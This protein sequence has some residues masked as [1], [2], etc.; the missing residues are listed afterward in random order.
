[1]VFFFGR[2][3]V[4]TQRCDL[5]VPADW[6]WGRSNKATSSKNTTNDRGRKRRPTFLLGLNHP[7]YSSHVGVI[8]MKMC[9]PMLA[10]APP[11]KFPGNRPIDDESRIHTWDIEMKYYSKYLIDLCV[12]WSDESELLFERSA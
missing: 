6:G 1:M 5:V 12:P 7:I 8:H 2:L 9:T 10:G 11:P 3:R 4:P